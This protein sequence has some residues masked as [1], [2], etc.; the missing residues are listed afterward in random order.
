MTV[1]QQWISFLS[2]VCDMPD[3][4]C[5]GN[6]LRVSSN[7]LLETDSAFDNVTWMLNIGTDV[8]Q[9]MGE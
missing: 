6:N 2:S 5:S 9:G 3:S 7:I 4:A 1:S 8:T